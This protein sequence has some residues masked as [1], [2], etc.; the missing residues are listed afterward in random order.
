M[1]TLRQRGMYAALISDVTIVPILIVLSVIG[2]ALYVICG[3]F[4]PCINNHKW[5]IYFFCSDHHLSW[6]REVKRDA[7]FHTDGIEFVDLPRY[8]NRWCRPC[9]HCCRRIR[10]LHVIKIGTYDKTKHVQEWLTTIGICQDLLL[11]C[12]FIQKE[13]LPL[14]R[15]QDV[16]NALRKQWSKA[17]TRNH[18]LKYTLREHLEEIVCINYGIATK[19][20]LYGRKEL[21]LKEIDVLHFSDLVNNRERDRVLM[22]PRIRRSLRKLVAMRMWMGDRQIETLINGNNHQYTN[23]VSYR[24]IS[25]PADVIQSLTNEEKDL[26]YTMWFRGG[27]LYLD[28][29]EGPNGEIEIDGFIVPNSGNPGPAEASGLV[30]YNDFIVAVNGVNLT[31]MSFDDALDVMVDSSWPQTIVF[32][33]DLDHHGIKLKREKDILSEY[34]KIENELMKETGNGSGS[35]SGSGETKSSGGGGDM[36]TWQEM[37]HEHTNENMSLDE[38]L[39]AIHLMEHHNMGKESVI[40]LEKR[41]LFF[42]TSWE[43]D[44]SNHHEGKILED[45]DRMEIKEWYQAMNIVRS[46]LRELASMSDDE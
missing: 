35:D 19:Y 20:S 32:K 26:Y 12:Q 28:I 21:K 11:E 5:P 29:S 42:I 9:V 6:S 3:M 41:L 16:T 7:L 33:R 31:G 27:P 23:N 46:R 37:L 15:I 39:E 34:L 25:G 1:G 2:L 44:W 13:F 40:E 38:T 22:D 4:I 36:P 8:H 43:E 10:Q 18:I 30:N 17:L 14:S 24:V 45:E